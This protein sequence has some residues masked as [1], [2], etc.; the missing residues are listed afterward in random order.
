M[1]KKANDMVKQVTKAAKKASDSGALKDKKALIKMA[2]TAKKMVT[3]AKKE[4]K[5]M[6]K[7]K[8]V[9]KKV[10]QKAP[11]AKGVEATWG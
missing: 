10:T 4:A 5:K 2:N 7:D 8:S 9:P 3:Q 11:K 6:V 1:A